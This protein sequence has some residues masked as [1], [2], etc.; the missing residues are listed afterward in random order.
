MKEEKKQTTVGLDKETSERMQEYL[1]EISRIYG[2]SLTE[3]GDFLEK[4]FESSAIGEHQWFMAFTIIDEIFDEMVAKI[5]TALEAIG[6]IK[7][8]WSTKDHAVNPSSPEAQSQYGARR[9]L[10]KSI[11]R[12]TQD[13][14]KEELPL[15]KQDE[16]GK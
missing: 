5:M 14:V 16:E 11:I 6:A 3:I 1:K 12:E 7:G 13:R 15:P 2:I 4:K 9:R 8:I 10:F